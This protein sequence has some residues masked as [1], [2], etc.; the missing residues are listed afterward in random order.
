[1]KRLFD[2]ILSILLLFL[3]AP[4]LAVCYIAIKCEDGGNPIFKQERIGLGGHP[5]Y[6]YKFRS[7]R[8]DAEADGP[9]LCN[10][11][12]DA[13]LT[14]VGNFLRRLHLDELPQLFNVLIGDMSFVGP[15]PERK[16]FIDQIMKHDPRY[17]ELYRIRPGVTSYAT[18]YNGYTDSME[19]MLKRLEYDLEYVERHSLWLD[20]KLMCTTVY[21]IIRGSRI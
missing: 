14:H 4:I 10:T 11:K 6:I 9:Q 8:I 18:I 12:G 17:V 15:R 7:M 13:R 20:I 16:H 5:F 3:F 2:L 21:K 1:M 19:K